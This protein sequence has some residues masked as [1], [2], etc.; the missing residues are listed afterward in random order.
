MK[1]HIKLNTLAAVLA[2]SI[3]AAA[4]AATMSNDEYAAG[5]DRISQAYKAS[6][7]KCDALSGNT[8]DICVA[9]AKAEEKRAKAKLDLDRQPD[10]RRQYAYAEANAEANYSVAIEK[11]D[12]LA[13]NAKDVCVKEA[14]AEKTKQ[15]ADAKVARDTKSA[16]ADA[17]A[18]KTDAENKI[19][20]ERCDALAGAAKDECV[21]NVKSKSR[22]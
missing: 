21:A 18:A 14:K 3:S 2:L 9:Q 22:P 7:Q 5:K 16:R 19:A 11:C 1:T 4:T 15:L 20:L 6:R 12:A 17:S 8:K 13:G 10:A